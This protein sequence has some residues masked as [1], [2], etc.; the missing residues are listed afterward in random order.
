[1]TARAPNWFEQKYVSGV[2]HRLQSQGFLMKPLINSSGTMN[3]NQVTWK[4][5]GTGV[6]TERKVGIE[7]RPVMNADRTTV[8]GTMRDYEANDWINHTD[9]DK[10]SENEQQVAQKTGAMALGRLFDQIIIREMDN[11]AGSIT[12]VGAGGTAISIVDILTA[13]A[14]IEDIGVGAYEYACILPPLLL[15]Q[16]ELFREFS[17]SDYVG[18]EYPLLKG[19][20]ARRFRGITF[21][22]MPSA[23]FTVPSAN[24]IDGYLFN[25]DCLGFAATYDSLRS[26]VDYVPEKKAYFAANDMSACPAVL[27]PEGIRRLRFAT[28]VALSR[29]TP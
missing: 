23:Y 16:L 1:M 11:A 15:S 9:L 13:K 19:I 7:N 28:N 3:G 20:G 26:R 6:A 18:D 21:V 27:L 5:A 29:P 25:V 22:P 8:V 2:V 10:M 14:Q 4:I 17:S 24:N 12:N